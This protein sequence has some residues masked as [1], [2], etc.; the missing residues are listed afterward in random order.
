[1][2]SLSAFSFFTPIGTMLFSIFI[3][4]KL[5]SNGN[6]LLRATS[7]V[8]ALFVIQSIDYIL[9]IG[10]T[11][12]LGNP[13]ELFFDFL[14]PGLIRIIF[15]VVDKVCDILLYLWA[16]KYLTKL[17]EIRN[18]IMA[19]LLICIT[20]AYGTMQYLIAMVLHGDFMQLQGAAIISFFVLLCF[21]F[22]LFFSM[23]ILT[24]SEKVKSTNQMLANLNQMMETNYYTLNESITSNA[25]AMHDFYHHLSVIDTL[26]QKEKCPSIT[27]YINSVL[28]TSFTPTQLC[29]SGNNIID[30]VINSKL[31][32]ANQ[33]E[34]DVNYTIHIDDLSSFEQADICAILANQIEN[35]FEACEKMKNKRNVRIDI[36][37]QEWFVLFRV[38]NSVISNPF[39]ENKNLVSTKADSAV[40]HGLGLKNIQDIAEKYN[41]SL[42]N[43]YADG[44]FISTV[45]IC[46]Q[47]I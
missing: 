10:V 5:V 33:K 27:E 36:R 9:I 29:R 6:V 32:E 38:T 18:R 20:L 30:A 34:I 4:G 40:V 14:E 13:R 17:S 8:L 22:I 3:V 1:M 28:A 2:N 7:C 45:L 21:I 42:K 23:T 43:E 41:G 47:T 35:A 26:A 11:F 46:S 24:V 16:K 12:P 19:F 39:L 31:D 15:L 37:Q 44:H 25:K